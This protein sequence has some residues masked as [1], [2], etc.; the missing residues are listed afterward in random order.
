MSFA[1]SL[2]EQLDALGN[3][4]GMD[5]G[6]DDVGEASPE[7]Q[8]FADLLAS[9]GLGD[10][11]VT[12]EK[13]GSDAI[14]QLTDSE[15]DTETVVFSVDEEGNPFAIVYSGI[16]G[17]DTIVIDISMLEPPLGADGGVDLSD[18]SWINRSTLMAIL[19][20]G[21]IGDAYTTAL[22]ADA[23]VEEE[24]DEAKDTK[25]K[26]GDTVTKLGRQGRVVG[27]KYAMKG[28]KKVK[29]ALI[30]WTGTLKGKYAAAM[31]KLQRVHKQ[32]GA[33]AVRKHAIAAKIGQRMGIYKK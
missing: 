13:D 22:E 29:V 32:K 17:E 19:A 20:P 14:L 5:M 10:I 27:V 26:V 6:M 3:E 2:I 4:M 28:Q 12:I 24:V 33:Q 23:E 18:P 9:Y 21:E 15:G 31:G 7:A 25:H 8:A 1:K 11:Q 16:E 30:K